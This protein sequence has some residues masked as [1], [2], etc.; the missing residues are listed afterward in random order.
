MFARYEMTPDEATKPPTTLADLRLPPTFVADHCI[1]TLASQG[2][3]TLVELA[4]HWRVPG[5][6]A[7]QAIEPTKLAGLIETET[8]RSNLESL[9]K[10]RLS[11]SGQARVETARARTWYAGPLPVS[12]SQYE[13][14]A[15]APR[16]ATDARANL[17]RALAGFFV[18][19]AQAEQIAQAVAS[20]ASIAFG[21]CAADEQYALAAALHRCLDGT[22]AVP[23][24]IFA[25]GAVM[26]LFDPRV[27]RTTK[28]AGDVEGDESEILRGRDAA[29]QWTQ[30]ARPLVAVSG[31]VLPTDV[32]PP[33]DED[34]R[35]YL[36]PAPLVA[37]GGLL[38]IC[39]AGSSDP[40]ALE[41]LARY[42]M[43][44]ARRGGAVL[45]LRTGERIE[46]PWTASLVVFA[47]SDE[48]PALTAG[49]VQYAVDA[50]AISGA[51]LRGFL[52]ARLNA[53]A[54]NADAI[55]T[56]ASLLERTDL[57][58]RSSGAAVASYL[59]DCRAYLG[60]DFVLS[61]QTLSA[62]LQQA[63]RRPRPTLR[64]AA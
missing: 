51:Q 57:A 24:A 12:L 13:R 20:G 27:H 44:P 58:T 42:W 25:A 53:A 22:T 9:Q 46:I 31:G 21:G 56:I 60:R 17:R 36:A 30:A 49:A 48:L 15:S 35:F 52:S 28:A 1:R 45:L 54:L 59:V 2:A 8:N 23:Q 10:W 11:A 50:S 33:F 40:G 4:K 39:D 43:V 55:E 3:M 6:V 62:A 34:A 38:A 19:E 29:A 64:Q 5:E 47:S 14:R 16:P 41:A 63:A 18:S 7:L 37:A 32:I 61:D 26:R